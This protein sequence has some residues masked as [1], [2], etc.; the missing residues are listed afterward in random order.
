MGA[1][2]LYIII[3]FW[4]EQVKKLGD[5]IYIKY[6]L[7]FEVLKSCFSWNYHFYGFYVLV[8]NT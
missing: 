4:F 6:E 7:L 3:L 1:K 2:K 5:W 8:K